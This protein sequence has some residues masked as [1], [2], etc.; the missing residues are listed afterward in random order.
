MQSYIISVFV[1]VRGIAKKHKDQDALIKGGLE[2]EDA[3]VTERAGWVGGGG[4]MQAR[5]AE[6]G[7]GKLDHQFFF[8]I[9]FDLRD[10]TVSVSCY[11]GHLQRKRKFMWSVQNRTS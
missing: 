9:H 5:E 10:C 1:A 7:N 2:G 3:E 11:L 6:S 8:S 4:N